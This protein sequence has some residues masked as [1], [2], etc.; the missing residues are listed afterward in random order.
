MNCS[1]FVLFSF[2]FL[3]FVFCF[4]FVFDF[5]F[6]LLVYF[7]WLPLCVFVL[8]LWFFLFVF[9][10]CFFLSNTPPL[11][12]WHTKM[13]L[14]AAHGRVAMGWTQWAAWRK[15]WKAVDDTGLRTLD[16]TATA[17]SRVVVKL[18]FPGSNK[19]PLKQVKQQTET[20]MLNW[21]CFTC[22]RLCRK[23]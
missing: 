18:E 5:V 12:P 20:A 2:L 19:K 8:F 4:V 1:Q 15:L 9:C 21:N 16:S 22:C 6:L 17:T 7:C 3:C 14:R 10:F 11:A 13:E 23:S